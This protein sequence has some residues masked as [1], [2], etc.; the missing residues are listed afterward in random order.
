MQ[1]VQPR[2]SV[3]EDQLE[4]WFMAGLSAEA[5]PVEDMLGALSELRLAGMAAQADSWAELLEES[6]VEKGDADAVIRVLRSR[7]QSREADPSYRQHVEKRLGWIFRN[8][9]LRKTFVPNAGFGKGI[10][11]MECFRRMESLMSLRDGILA[12]DK[13]WGIGRVKHVDSFYQRVTIDFTRK[14]GHEMSMAYAAETIQLVGEDHLQARHYQNP[15]G[16]QALVA[17]N[18]AEVVKITLRSYGPLPVPLLQEILTDGIIK[19]EAWKGF[20]DAARKALKGDPLV[21]IPPKRND[22]VSLLDQEVAYDARWFELLAKERTCEGVFGRLEELQSGLSVEEVDVSGRRTIGDR[23]SFLLRGFGG[24]DLSVK[25]Q[26]AMAARQWQVPEESVNWTNEVSELLNPETLLSAATQLTAR[27]LDLFLGMMADYDAERVKQVILGLLPR[28]SLNVLNVFMDFMASQGAE[29]ACAGVFREEL[30]QRKIG[31]EMAF[32]LAKRP[33]KLAEWRLG[34]LGDLMF[35]VLPL[36]ER[37]YMFDR[38]RAAN[39][40]AELVQQRKW[41]EVS[42]DS[43][44]D[45]QR[46]SL[47]RALRAIM[48]RTMLD[49]QAMIGRICVGH[50]ELAKLLVETKEESD[51]TQG[52][53]TSWRSYRERQRQLDKLVNED[54]PRNSQDIGVARSYGDLRENFEYKTAKE[55]QGILMRRR[56][57]WEQDL[58]KVKGTDFVG[59]AADVAGLGTTVSLRYADGTSHVFHLMGEWDQDPDRG[60]ISCS[61]K[62]G[63]ALAGHRKGDEVLVPGESGDLNCVLTDV[64]ALPADILAW[65]KGS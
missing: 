3:G 59:F 65:A 24:T 52:G 48:G 47:I 10:P 26:V 27:R 21:V 22:P 36:F 45:I 51:T 19:P 43:M 63:K 33:E 55:Q 60:I 42:V 62:M 37:T 57:E 58:N 18:P 38:L 44:N 50:P 53:L 25:V 46:T 28:A 32:W 14:R 34:T 2:L 61:S 9:P 23:L 13:T 40:L 20:W 16:L 15:E 11:L 17:E 8:D 6:L 4:E 29:A 31:V 54:I 30:G 12:M 5:I 35:H 56:G 41:L 1:N 7:G 49:T 39:Q 64:A